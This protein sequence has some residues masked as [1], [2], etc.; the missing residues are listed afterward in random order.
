MFQTNGLCHDFCGPQGYAYGVT[1]SNS[2][3]CSNYTPAQSSQVSKSKCNTDCPGYPSEKCGGA[4]LFAYVVVIG[5]APSGT[6]GAGDGSSSTSIP[7]VSLS[8]TCLR[9]CPQHVPRSFCLLVLGRLV[10]A[11]SLTVSPSL[12]IFIDIVAAFP[13]CSFYRKFCLPALCVLQHDRDRRFPRKAIWSCVE[14]PLCVCVALTPETGRPRLHP[15]RLHPACQYLRA[16]VSAVS[17]VPAV[18]L[19]L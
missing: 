2:C 16:A 14:S 7:D 1:Q 9:C 5:V 15:R 17:A 18:A 10:V 13:R 19:P 6:K 3:W 12:H 4:G 8:F 11:A